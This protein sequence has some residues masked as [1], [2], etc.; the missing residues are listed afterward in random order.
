MDKLYED[1]S[2]C[3]FLSPS[4]PHGKNKK[5][6][7]K[8][9][10]FVIER[11]AHLDPSAS[12]SVHRTGASFQLV[13]DSAA[14]TPE[15]P[16]TR[17]IVPR[18][19][20]RNGRVYF[21]G[22]KWVGSYRGT[23]VNPETGERIRGRSRSMLQSHR[24]EL[25]AVPST[26]PG[27]NQR[28]IAQS[29]R[30]RKE[31]LS[32]LIEEWKRE[33]LPN[34]KLGGARD[35]LSHIRTYITPLLGEKPSHE[36]DAKEHQV[37]VT[38]VGRC[39][40]RRKTAENVY[41]TLTSILNKGRKWGYFIPEVKR[42][43][44]EFLADEK[45]KDEPFFFDANTAARVINAAPYPFKVM[46][47]FAAICGLGIGEVTALKVGSLDFKRKL[48]HITAALDYA[49]RK[50]ST[51]KSHNS[52]AP[53]HMPELLVK[54]LRDWTDKRYRPNPDGYLF[55]NSK[56][57]PYP[58]D[59]VI[60]YGIHRAMEKLGIQT[61]ARSSYWDSLFSTRRFQSHPGPL[62]ACHWRDRARCV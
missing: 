43:D 28:P 58:S 50:E 4:K 12:E 13:L 2:A 32:E 26:L 24:R 62:R 6:K 22:S 7:R 39:V 59:N 11:R 45:P 37:F 57:R 52:E 42:Q 41:G 33:I 3:K 29:A 1:S 40:D 20:F 49:T 36:L 17:R 10:N 55:L 47:L 15:A 16:S 54:H 8:D 9:S 60:K 14:A 35:S 19:R 44:I 31:K 30:Q 53:L 34:R 23:E 5:T 18:R 38:A 48:L 46:F 21:R 56:G 61:A 51:P 27:P 25:L